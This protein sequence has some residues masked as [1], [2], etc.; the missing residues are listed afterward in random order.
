MVNSVP[1]NKDSSAYIKS[2]LKI[3]QIL[4]SFIE[5]NQEKGIHELSNNTGIPPSTLQ[6]LV[7]TL[8][9]KGYLMQ[10]PKTLKYRLG[11]TFYHL[12]KSF[13][14]TFNWVE[15]AKYYM[16]RFVSKH[17]ETLNLSYLEG[18]NIVYLV[19]ADSSHILRPNFNIG[20]K[21]P[22]YCTALGKCLLAYLPPDFT[23]RYFSEEVFTKYTNNTITSFSE[24]EDELSKIRKQGFAV[25]DEEFQDDLRCI[26]VPIKNKKMDNLVIASL[27]VTAPKSRMSMERLYD[28][29]DDLIETAAKISES[30]N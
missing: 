8:R 23:I 26:A 12:Y 1:K 10:N 30:I 17:N 22:V 15:E 6:R 25:D 5:N 13:S 9:V 2:A 24:L 3:F 21:Y 20:T 28:I 18:K 19:K 11:F 4:E 16:E 14:Q 29:K 27:S 7:N